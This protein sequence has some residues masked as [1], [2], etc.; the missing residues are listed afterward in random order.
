VNYKVEILNSGSRDRRWREPDN[1]DIH[2]S[3]E[4]QLS[5]TAFALD[6]VGIYV[7]PRDRLERG[8]WCRKDT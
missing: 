8:R 4:L 1:D 3:Y 7:A 5:T 2:L 6:A